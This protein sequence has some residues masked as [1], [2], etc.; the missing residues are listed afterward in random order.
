MDM[1]SLTALLR[2]SLTFFVCVFDAICLI[3]WAQ[4]VHWIKL[5]SI[6]VT[7]AFD[8][9]ISFVCSERF[10]CRWI[11]PSRCFLLC[12]YWLSALQGLICYFERLYSGGIVHLFFSFFSWLS[13]LKSACLTALPTCLD[14]IL[15]NDHLL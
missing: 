4:N 9:A 3:I 1:N 5:F 10:D 8:R 12:I 15:G 14:K 7:Q 11:P 2:L 6:H 13:C